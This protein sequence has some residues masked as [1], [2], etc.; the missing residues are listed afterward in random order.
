MEAATSQ[1]AALEI[2]P[3]TVMSLF[4][5]TTGPSTAMSRPS[6]DTVQGMLKCSNSR[7]VWSRVMAGWCTEVRPSASI[8]ASST[9]LF[10]WALAMGRS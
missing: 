4:C 8:P 10:T 5:G 2:S 7:S 9:A 1:K 6:S 3:G